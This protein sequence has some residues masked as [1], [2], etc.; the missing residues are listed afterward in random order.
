MQ[1]SPTNNDGNRVVI[2]WLK[3]S[4]PLNGDLAFVMNTD[5]VRFGKFTGSGNSILGI[6]SIGAIYRANTYSF[7]D[8]TILSTKYWVNTNFQSKLNGSSLQYVRG[9]GTY[10]TFPTDNTSFTN[11]AGYITQPYAPIEGE[12]INITGGYPN[13]TISV[14]TSESSSGSSAIM[15][16]GKANSAI[17]N[18]QNGINGKQTTLVSG[19]NIKTIETQSILGSGNIDVT[20]SDVGLSNVDNTSDVNKPISTATST[21]LSGKQSTLV[22]ATNIKTIN[23]NSLLGSGDLSISTGEVNTASNV[24]SGLGVYKQKS[25]VDL[26]FKSLLGTTNQITVTNN[27]NDITF[28][29]PTRIM[30][31]T[32]RSLVTTT[33]STGYQISSTRDYSVNYSVYAQV[34]SALAGTNTAD[35]FL[36]IATTNSTTPSDWTTISRSGISLAGVLSMSGNTQTVGG[37]IPSGYYV[38]IRVLATG[39]NSGSAVFT[40]QVGQENT[41]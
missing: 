40:Y 31:A 28:S 17:T 1:M 3:G 10:G 26:Q 6:N 16:M 37:F 14:D 9:N 8:T 12:G 11:G 29:L 24:G 15:Y 27:T 41:Y 7:I 21:A 30:S 13:Q 25:G 23:G 2:G 38:R 19:T 35:V 33:S 36:E 18:L 34:S 32:S 20:K 5:T 39:S 4:Y 22:S